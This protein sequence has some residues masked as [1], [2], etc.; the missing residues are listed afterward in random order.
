MI[1]HVSVVSWANTHKHS[2]PCGNIYQIQL[3][4]CTYWRSVSLSHLLL[5]PP[6]THTHTPM[7]SCEALSLSLCCSSQQ[8]VLYVF[9][10][11]NAHTQVQIH[12]KS[13]AHL[14]CR[15]PT[16]DLFSSGFMHMLIF[17][18][19]PLGWCACALSCVSIVWHMQV[20]LCDCVSQPAA[21]MCWQC[22]RNSRVSG[23]KS[24]SKWIKTYFAFCCSA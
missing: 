2:L 10:D 8:L 24:Q 5:F 1:Q 6:S 15:V 19:S 16:R 11:F 17:F 22:V 9:T 4:E 12:K 18:Q 7:W 14:P 20:C 3:S 23:L 13:H 21:G